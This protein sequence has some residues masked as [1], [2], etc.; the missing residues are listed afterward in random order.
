Y[1]IGRRRLPYFPGRLAPRVQLFELLLVLERVHAAPVTL[2]LVGQQLL[3]CDQPL[4]RLLDQLL[5]RLDVVEDFGAEGEEAPVNPDPGLA[6][7]PY[8]T[9][10]VSVARHDVVALGRWD[11]HEA[12]DFSPVLE[13]LD[14]FRQRQVGQP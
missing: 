7:G 6:D 13:T 8:F 10:H 14:V 5:A 9:N 4:E 1:V 3:L 11:R 2:V 12:G